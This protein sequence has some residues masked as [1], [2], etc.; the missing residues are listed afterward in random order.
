M[1]GTL[2]TFIILMSYSF[3]VLAKTQIQFLPGRAARASLNFQKPVE[4]SD[5]K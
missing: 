5:K 4:T 3:S 2:L 1:A